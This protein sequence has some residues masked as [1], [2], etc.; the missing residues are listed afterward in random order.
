MIK[1]KL[2]IKCRHFCGILEKT[3]LSIS[4]HDI[5]SDFLRPIL[6]IQGRLPDDEATVEQSRD[7]GWQDGGSQ[8]HHSNF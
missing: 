5:S 4:Q 2:K 1:V 6:S 7:E 3:V 8:R